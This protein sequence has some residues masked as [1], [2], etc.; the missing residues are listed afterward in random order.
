MLLHVSIVHSFLLLRSSK[1]YIY[2]SLFN[3]LPVD[4][5]MP[6]CFPKWLSLQLWIKIPVA[7]HLG[8]LVSSVLL[9][10]AILLGV[11]W[12]LIV[13][14]ICFSLVTNGIECL[15]MCLFV[16]HISSFVKYL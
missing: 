15:F 14:F 2:L 8:P 11:L 3:Y 16:I 10:L 12:H 4:E 9:I 6:K 5:Q 1:I 7:L 13:I